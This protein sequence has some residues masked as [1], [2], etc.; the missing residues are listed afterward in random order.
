MIGKKDFHDSV[1]GMREEIILQANRV[2]EKVNSNKDDLIDHLD[3]LKKNMIDEFDVVK[4]AF[5]RKLVQLQL[6]VHRCHQVVKNGNFE[7]VVHQ[8]EDLR[9]MSQELKRPLANIVK[10]TFGRWT[11]ATTDSELP[12]LPAGGQRNWVGRIIRKDNEIDREKQRKMFRG[13]REQYDEDHR[14]EFVGVNNA[15]FSAR[16]VENGSDNESR[17]HGQLLQQLRSTMEEKQE[18]KK[19]LLC[20]KIRLREAIKQRGNSSRKC[21][22]PIVSESMCLKF[23]LIC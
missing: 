5:G 20:C 23:N 8:F 14:G 7:D 12:P 9:S 18:L 4:I 10:M 2:V 1:S 6:F 19:D 15:G 13:V 11:F 22:S 21:P 17:T 16:E 3:T